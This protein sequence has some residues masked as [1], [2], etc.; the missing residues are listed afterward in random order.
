M[1]SLGVFC[2]QILSLNVSVSTLYYGERNL[3]NDSLCLPR[4][5][6]AGE[7]RCHPSQTNWIQGDLTEE[8]RTKPCSVPQPNK[9]TNKWEACGTDLAAQGQ[10][11]IN[12]KLFIYGFNTRIKNKWCFDTGSLQIANLPN[13]LGLSGQFCSEPLF[14][15]CIFFPSLNKS[16]PL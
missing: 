16:E 5:M 11:Q 8:T 1:S 10:E 4:V 12:R 3:G 9:I 6:R 15:C 13:L 7:G 14:V 2:G